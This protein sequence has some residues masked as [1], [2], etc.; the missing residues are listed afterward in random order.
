MGNRLTA[1]R[2]ATYLGSHPSATGQIEKI[3][4]EFHTD[5]VTFLKGRSE[6]GSLPWSMVFNVDADERGSLS[7][8]RG[9][10]RLT[11]VAYLVITDS[12]GEWIFAISGLNA[13][14]LRAGLKP[15]A[16]YFSRQDSAVVG[17]TPGHATPGGA[18]IPEPA[19][20]L[21]KLNSLL[22]SGLVTADEY[23]QRRAAIIAEI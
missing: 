16:S 23:S 4:V 7:M 21:R 22:E 19:E 10:K 15:L 9:G 5:G 1:L 18:E 2:S 20:R 3:D 12:R 13:V 11:T 14:E 6:I 8:A 17:P